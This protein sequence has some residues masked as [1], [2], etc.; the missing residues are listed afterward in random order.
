MWENWYT[1]SLIALF[2]M[3]T[4]R[5]LYKVS[6]QRGCNTAWTTFTFM[7]TV[8]FLSVIFFFIS[9]EPVSGIPFLLFIALINSVS[10]TL[11]T[12]SHIEALNHLPASV[13]YPII[14]LN[15]AVV[16]VFS[17]FF[18]HDRLSG[19]QI[20]GIL[21]A[22]AVIILLAKESNGQDTT[23]RDIRRGFSLVAVCV[24]C[25][26][27]AS[28]SSKFAAMHTNKMAFIALSYFMGTLFSFA[29]RNRLETETTEAFRSDAVIIGIIMGLLN[30]AGFY[31]FLSALAIGP[32]SIVV[33]IMGLHFIIP[34]ILATVIY[35]EKLTPLRILGV[36]LTTVSVIFL[37][38]GE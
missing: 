38:Y 7:G 15:A 35:S 3:G 20:V 25:G 33:S 11:A 13:A 4:Q 21:I 23:R 28:I 34:I 1:L 30:F 17:V 18:F 36:L 2:F 9:H 29:F 27:I 16:V 12:L 14:R 6:A 26:A 10:F 8:T 24:V 31:A 32:L 22:I 5:F 37:K 19:Y